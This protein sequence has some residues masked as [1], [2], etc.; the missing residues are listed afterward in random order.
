MPLPIQ[1][2]H[3]GC[4]RCYIKI[5][6]KARSSHRQCRRQPTQREQLLAPLTWEDQLSSLSKNGR[7][8][9]LRLPGSYTQT[10]QLQPQSVEMRQRGLISMNLVG[11]LV[12][13]SW[14]RPHLGLGGDSVTAVQVFWKES[15]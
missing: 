3:S 12:A 15:P 9:Y 5:E 10:A 1:F 4:N 14:R 13:T 2:A 11:Y 7:L 8:G 6:Y